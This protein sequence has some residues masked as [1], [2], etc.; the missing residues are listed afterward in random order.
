MAA[1][2]KKLEND[3]ENQKHELKKIKEKKMEG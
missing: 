3:L 1:E 2:I